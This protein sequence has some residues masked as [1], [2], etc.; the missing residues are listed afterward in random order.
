MCLSLPRRFAAEQDQINQIL[1]RVPF[2][3]KQL[4]DMTE[5]FDAKMAQTADSFGQVEHDVTAR[6]Q[7]LNRDMP[8]GSCTTPSTGTTSPR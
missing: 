3:L 8:W 7:R 5:A 6:I 2:V 4:R 1:A